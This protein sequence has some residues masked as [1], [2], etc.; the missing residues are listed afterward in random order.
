MPRKPPSQLALPLAANPSAQRALI[1][2]LV[3]RCLCGVPCRYHGREMG[4]HSR[5][6]QLLASGRYR[7]IE[8]CPEVDAGLSTPR[9]PTRIRNGRCL[10]AGQD[11]TAAFERGAEIALAR[12]KESGAER[13]YL[14]S[15]SPSCDGDT[16][17]TGKALAQA[18]LRI[19]KI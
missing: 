17:I 2:V 16:G 3:S 11:I 19:I 6:R 15:G 7:L 5:V 1:P 4:V 9:P 10:C 12:A 14:V 8:V 13:A 18:G